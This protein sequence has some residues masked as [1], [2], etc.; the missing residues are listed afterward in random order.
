ME[1]VET[2][3]AV[4][5]CNAVRG[6]LPVARLGDRVWS[7]HPAIDDARR[8]LAAAHYAFAYPAYDIASNEDA[9]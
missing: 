4:V 2:A 7:P 5:L 6:I 9:P 1:E 8:R 3:D